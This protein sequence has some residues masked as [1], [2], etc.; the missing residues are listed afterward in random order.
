M[1]IIHKS[2][3]NLNLRERALLLRERSYAL[4]SGSAMMNIW[5]PLVEISIVAKQGGE[6]V[7]ATERKQK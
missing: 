6:D 3:N 1:L 2:N 5:T 7:K 4:A